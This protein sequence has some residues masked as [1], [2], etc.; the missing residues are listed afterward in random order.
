MDR[1]K[2][3][4]VQPINFP[5]FQKKETIQHI[6]WGCQSVKKQ[7][8]VVFNNFPTIFE[9]KLNWK[10]ALLGVGLHANTIANGVRHVILFHLW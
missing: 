1:M 4:M 3:S 8:N 9:H 5:F 2:C 10:E 7:W 6:F